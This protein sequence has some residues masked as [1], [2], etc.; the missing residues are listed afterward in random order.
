MPWRALLHG[1]STVATEILGISV[2]LS[3]G[4]VSIMS[5]LKEINGL[6]QTLSL[7]VTIV[8]GILTAIHIHSKTRAINKGKKTED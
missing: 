8:V 2:T 3:A 5:L 6:L 4:T 7:L 1:I